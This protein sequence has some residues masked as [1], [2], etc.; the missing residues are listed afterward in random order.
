MS[1]DE[2]NISGVNRVTL[3]W[4]VEASHVESHFH[5]RGPGG[6]LDP[7]T[8][9]A[10]VQSWYN[11]SG[12]TIFPANVVL[13]SIKAH[14]ATSTGKGFN[15]GPQAL[16]E[17]AGITGTASG[18]TAPGALSVLASL[19]SQFPQRY[20]NGRMFLPPPPDTAY[21]QSVLTTTYLTTLGT[22]ATNFLGVFGS[23]GS[24]TLRLVT[25][26]PGGT[27]TSGPLAGTTWNMGTATVQA[28]RFPSVM[29]VQ[30]RR[31][32]GIGI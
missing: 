27:Y 30:R 22:W 6:L 17:L 2:T 28:I 24:S 18:A 20:R 32:P 15:T 3:I 8:T 10:E 1:V 12:K 16:V 23:S 9:A 7:A 21:Q 19:R 4:Q 14:Q 26:T 31:R 29:S 25:F 11:S 13:R 5:L